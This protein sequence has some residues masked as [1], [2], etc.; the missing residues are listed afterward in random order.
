M[1]SLCAEWI[2]EL[3]PLFEERQSII[4]TTAHQ[5][6]IIYRLR[7]ERPELITV[8]LAF[9]RLRFLVPGFFPGSGD[10][11]KIGA[12]FFKSKQT[13]HLLFIP[14]GREEAIG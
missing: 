2:E 13:S 14:G 4:H 3:Q 1:G 12:E 7:N 6:S 11:T 9:G 5:R 10:A 8:E